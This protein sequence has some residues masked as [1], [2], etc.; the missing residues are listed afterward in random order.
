MR[1]V[2]VS[3]NGGTPKR[4][5]PSLTLEDKENATPPK[6]TKAVGHGRP[7]SPLV[8]LSP[9]V[10]D[11]ERRSSRTGSPL[12][13]WVETE[14]EDETVRPERTPRLNREAIYSQMEEIRRRQ[15]RLRARQGLLMARMN[16]PAATSPLAITPSVSSSIKKAQCKSAKKVTF[17][18]VSPA[19]SPVHSPAEYPSTRDIKT[20]PK[21]SELKGNEPQPTSPGVLRNPVLNRVTGMPSPRVFLPPSSNARQRWYPL[22]DTTDLYHEALADQEVSLFTGVVGMTLGAESQGKVDRCCEPIGRVFLEGD[23]QVCKSDGIL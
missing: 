20:S 10:V 8:D 18:G 15:E 19:G 4:P 11:A 6:R 16:D 13:E 5:R 7:S 9:N 12:A 23:D 3:S 2:G 14:E 1:A 21:C 17:A 22:V